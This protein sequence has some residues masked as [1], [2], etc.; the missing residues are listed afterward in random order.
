[1]EKQYNGLTRHYQTGKAGALLSFTKFF[2]KHKVSPLLEKV[3]AKSKAIQRNCKW[4]YCQ[5]RAQDLI[6]AMAPV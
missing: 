4:Q 3:I 5:R 1:M 2:A 6:D